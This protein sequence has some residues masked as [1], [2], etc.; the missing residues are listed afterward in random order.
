MIIPFNLCFKI[1]IILIPVFK[2]YGG[3][4]QSR[5]LL[6]EFVGNA[7]RKTDQRNDEV[8]QS[9]PFVQSG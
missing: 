5:L 8:R 4:W 9:K 2:E 6:G 7:Y 3:P 1:V